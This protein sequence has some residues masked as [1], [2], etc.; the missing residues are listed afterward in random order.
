MCWRARQAGKHWTCKSSGSALNCK[1]HHVHHIC[2]TTHAL[3]WDGCKRPKSVSCQK[4]A[5]FEQLRE[6]QHITNHT[7]RSSG[8]PGFLPK[9][10]CNFMEC[11][12]SISQEV[13]DLSCLLAWLDGIF[14][15]QTE[16]C[17]LH[18]G[19]R[20]ST[21]GI[22]ELLCLK[23]AGAQISLFFTSYE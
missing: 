21:V 22:N 2:Y 5:M 13:F 6:I 9:C 4:I 14:M 7:N 11:V 16:I 23:N 19:T 1:Q 20:E 10:K 15:W 3:W 17:T 12:S 8:A 18:G